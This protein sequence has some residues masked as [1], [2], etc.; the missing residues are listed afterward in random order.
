MNQLSNIN[1][2]KADQFAAIQT[3]DDGQLYFVEQKVTSPMPNVWVFPSGLILQKMVRTNVQ[4]NTLRNQYAQGSND[5]RIPMTYPMAF[6][7]GV[8]RI[9]AYAEENGSNGPAAQ[10]AMEWTIQ[11]LGADQPPTLTQ[12]WLSASRITGGGDE[13]VNLVCW[14]EGY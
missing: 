9:R 11:A 10:E 8:L 14:A 7:N 6:P 1:I 4:I 12:C 3:L 2:L 13:Q 5:Y